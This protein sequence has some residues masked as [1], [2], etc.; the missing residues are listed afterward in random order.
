MPQLPGFGLHADSQ[1]E[2]LEARYTKVVLLY[3]ERLLKTSDKNGNGILDHD[4]WQHTRWQGDPRKSDLNKDGRLTKAELCEHL[5]KQ[6]GRRMVGSAATSS[7]N[8]SR[9][10]QSRFTSSVTSV[11]FLVRYD[12]NKD[13]VL[14]PDEIE[15]RLRRV[16]DRIVR[17]AGF[18]PNKP[19]KLSELNQAMQSRSTG[20]SQPAPSG[21][22]QS[23]DLPEG[24]SYKVEGS[25]LT[26]RKS[27]RSPAPTERLP[28][29]LPNLWFLCHSP[30]CFAGTMRTELPLM[31]CGGISSRSFFASF[32]ASD[33]GNRSMS[34]R[35]HLSAVF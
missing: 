25:K 1:T 4:E 8:A 14:H 9:A 30:D 18:D 26:G 23:G 32:T 35:S 20:A 5:T 34:R 10:S 13:G 31:A 15:P 7:S 19:V 28:E 29:G 21:S 24:A 16:T 11:R 22:K 3:V 6:F 12:A 2:V 33:F 27:Y 17:N